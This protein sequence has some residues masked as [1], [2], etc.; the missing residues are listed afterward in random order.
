MGVDPKKL[1]VNYCATDFVYRRRVIG[2]VGYPQPNARKRESILMDLAWT[3]DLSPFQ[4]IFTGEGWGEFVEQLKMV[5]V[6]ADCIHADTEQKLADIYSRLDLLLVT[7]YVEGGPLPLLEAMASG[8]KV[9]S[10]RFGYAADFLHESDLYNGV[11]ELAASL[12]VWVEDNIYYHQLARAWS[13]K[14]YVNEYAMLIGE[15][16]GESVDLYPERGQ[17][18]YMQLLDIIDEVKPL[19]IV[20]I[21]TWNGNRALQMIQ[22]AAKY[23]PI[24]D[25][26]YQGFD[27][28]EDQTGEQFRRELSKMGCS[29]RVVQK[30]LEATGSEIT[31]IQGETIYT[32]FEICN[33][34]DLYFIDGGH[35]EDTIDN[36][37]GMV[38]D[39][40][41]KSA[42]VIF[43][44][45][46][47]DGKPEGM[48]C[49]K[50]IEGLDREQFKV[51][52]LPAH[53]VADDGR[54]IGMVKVRRRNANLYLQVQGT[55]H[56][57]I[58]PNLRT[59][60]SNVT[61]SL[62]PMWVANAPRPTNGDGELE[63]L[64]PASGE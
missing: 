4:F 64:A 62:P 55:T 41:S 43:D 37:A 36:D 38:L 14:D 52:F 5:G 50:F 3:N 25:V 39:V 34:A 46:Y 12:R 8:V 19:G 57:R 58:D 17:S 44:D 40:L 11:D 35:S 6:Q 32:L 24:G 30:R 49:N 16:L 63:R 45:Y 28:F 22:R 10:P 29:K 26:Y 1:W 15:L 13:W 27:L 31:L 33:H 56:T 48:G 61:Y 54:V 21:G 9:L 42:V 18:R 23:K 60:G 59:S 7:G 51:T 47:L 20:E 53:T 2:I